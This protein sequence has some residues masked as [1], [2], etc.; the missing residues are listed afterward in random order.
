MQVML[1]PQHTHL[2]CYT[3]TAKTQTELTKECKK[4]Y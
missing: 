2:E 1:W 3:F 4:G